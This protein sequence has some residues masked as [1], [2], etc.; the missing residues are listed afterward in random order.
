MKAVPMVLLFL[1]V[2][3]YIKNDTMKKI[4]FLL[5]VL[6]STTAFSQNDY[7]VLFGCYGEGEAVSMNIIKKT[8]RLH[9]VGPGAAGVGIKKWELVIQVKKGKAYTFKSNSSLITA[10]MKEELE[11]NFKRTEY[12]LLQNVMASVFNPKTNKYEEVKMETVKLMLDAKAIAKCDEKNTQAIDD[13]VLQFSCFKNGDVASVKDIL[14][15]PTFTI[16]NSS[17]DVDIK[18]VS[19]NYV[20]PTMD[21]RRNPKGLKSIANT[22]LELNTQ[23]FDI[24]KRLQAGES[25]VLSDIVVQFTNRKTKSVE[26]ITVAPIVIEIANKSAE[27]CG[28]PG[29]D[30]LLVLEYS[31]KLLTGKDKNIPLARQKVYLKDSR[32]S[33]VQVTV[34]NSYGDFTFKNLKADENYLISIPVED[35]SKL[36]DMQL[37]LAKVDGT[38]LKTLEK[39]GNTFS[40]KV[41]PSELHV[42]AKQE[43]EDTELRIKKFGSSSQSELVVVED[44]YY[45]PNSAEISEESMKQL[46]KIVRAMKENPSLKLF[47]GSHTD[48]TGEDAYNMNLSEK[49]AKHVLNY[50]IAEGI[51]AQRLTAKGFGETQIKNRCK[52]GVDCSELEHELN[53]RTEFKFTK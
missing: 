26:T 46:D 38:I 39:T 10:Q 28:D 17:P 5:F 42:L 21:G 11:K 32:D 20:V 36:K 22:D 4:L 52:N 1:L 47:I 48:A 53:R 2:L 44:I 15:Y 18:I 30:T 12:I 50:L 8:K 34:T 35:N 24:A 27:Q 33:V 23:S 45:A 29:S 13:L 49:R 19:Y 14:H 7:K 40:Y 43:A 25:F 16:I 3:V 37:H 6:F 51:P 31:G 9:I 41:L